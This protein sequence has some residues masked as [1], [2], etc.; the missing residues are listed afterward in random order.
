MFHSISKEYEERKLAPMSM[1]GVK[2]ITCMAACLSVFETRPRDKAVNI[3]DQS[4]NFL[5]GF[6]LPA[7]PFIL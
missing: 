4:G 5:K 1:N 6:P 2:I 7:Q 3:E